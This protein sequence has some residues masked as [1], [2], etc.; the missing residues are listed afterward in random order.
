[1]AEKSK[2]KRKGRA[3]KATDIVFIDEIMSERL[4][5]YAN[6]EAKVSI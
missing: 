1:M 3:S 6:T 5:G 2:K 4:A